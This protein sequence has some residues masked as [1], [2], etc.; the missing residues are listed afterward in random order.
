M[1]N[2]KERQAFVLD[3]NNWHRVGSDIMGRVRL[4]ELEYK[5]HVWYRIEIF[6]QYTETTFP[7]H[8]S[9]IRE[10]KTGWWPIRMYVIDRETGAFS[11]TV[12][13]TMIVD[14]I[15]EIDKQEKKGGKN[16]GKN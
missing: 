4:R 14:A 9:Y 3:D 5:D 8:G 2:D 7:E 16:N 12:S 11:E 6:T 13:K 1:R 10:K 15:K